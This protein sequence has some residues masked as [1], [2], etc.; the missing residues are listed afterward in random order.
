MRRNLL[1]SYTIPLF[2]DSYFQTNHKFPAKGTDYH[3]ENS[4]FT[5]M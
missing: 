3:V 4:E 2:E 5:W 1:N